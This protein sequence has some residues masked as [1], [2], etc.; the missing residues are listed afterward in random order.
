M[1]KKPEGSTILQMTPGK[2][3]QAIIHTGRLVDS[4]CQRIRARRTSAA[5]ILRRSAPD[6]L[7]SR[8]SQDDPISVLI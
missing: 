6:R 2:D 8:P 5:R 4:V 3:W 7:S 1:E